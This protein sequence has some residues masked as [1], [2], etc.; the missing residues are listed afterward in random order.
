[1]ENSTDYVTKKDLKEALGK[2]VDDI[3]EV[4]RDGFSLVATKKEV[5]QLRSEMATK[6]DL[7]KLEQRMATKE[8]IKELRDE[9]GGDIAA[10]EKK[11]LED[12]SAIAAVHD[13]EH[14][15]L[16]HRVEALE[17][18]AGFPKTH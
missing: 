1:M 13:T 6:D 10:L 18:H 3:T 8:D 5:E 11:L 2:V 7:K 4:I 15:L 12:S 14:E 17:H 9:I 16:V